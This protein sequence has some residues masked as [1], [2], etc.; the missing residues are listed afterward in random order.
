[1]AAGEDVMLDLQA[2]YRGGLAGWIPPWQYPLLG[3]G[4]SGQAVRWTRK[5]VRSLKSEELGFAGV[6]ESE[7]V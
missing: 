4:A 3:R 2:L 5:A 1:V 6:V 7:P